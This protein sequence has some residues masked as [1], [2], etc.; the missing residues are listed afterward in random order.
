MFWYDK[1]Q[2]RVMQ[3]K[4]REIIRELEETKNRIL[5]ELSGVDKVTLTRLREVLADYNRID[6]N[7]N[8]KIK[9]FMEN[10]NVIL[11]G[12]EEVASLFREEIRKIS[13]LEAQLNILERNLD[14]VT[15]L[16]FG[17]V[18]D[19]VTD[20]SDAMIEAIEKGVEYG[21][22]VVI[23][24]NVNIGVRK[25]LF[26]PSNLH[27]IINGVLRPI[28]T[29]AMSL[30]TFDRV[31][32]TPAYTS[33][34][35]V[36]IEGN[37]VID[38]RCPEL[39]NYSA[40]IRI[41]HASNVTIKD[42]T[43][44]NNCFFHFIEIGASKNVTID[45]VK[46]IDNYVDI[47][48]YE[49]Y[50]GYHEF[51]QLEYLTESGAN[52]AIPFDTT[53]IKNL[54]IK[55]CLFTKTENGG[56]L[57]CA[58]GSHTGYLGDRENHDNI[59]I[60]NCIFENGDIPEVIDGTESIYEHTFINIK[61]H[62]NN[63][64]IEKCHFKNGHTAIT[65]N[66]SNVGTVKVIGNIF[67]DIKGH[68]VCD[69]GSKQADWYYFIGNN[70]FNCSSHNNTTQNDT[71]ANLLLRDDCM[72]SVVVNNTFICK[73]EYVQR[74]IHFPRTAIEKEKN[75]IVYGNVLSGE[76]IER[77]NFE[78][79]SHREEVLWSG[80][81]YIGEI[82]VPDL[83]K[84]EEVRIF[85]DI[86]NMPECDFVTLSKLQTQ[87]INKIALPDAPTE[88]SSIVIHEVLYTTGED[89]LTVVC[90]N[91]CLIGKDGLSWSSKNGNEAE[92]SH[93]VKITKI[94]GINHNNQFFIET[95]GE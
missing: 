9:T 29:D 63:V 32:E 25:R 61:P 87:R 73:G 34:H 65:F 59:L 80:N 86:D 53:P 39:E 19:G 35:N 5:K 43:L 72:D 4:K 57:K 91:R 33:S 64:V 58:I 69:Y 24:A 75:L 85:A 76:N 62:F 66:G 68:C 3:H 48:N 27:L 71:Y 38:M 21:V 56:N 81:H 15:P 70:F 41:Y 13:S 94:V 22:P 11:D 50:T 2:E 18:G 36:L 31:T 26:T 12:A 55:N 90:N 78:R 23:P 40:P 52:G 92:G 42:I 46:F 45:N 37:G 20:D 16:M 30:E 14:Y 10:G 1:D 54:T 82:T 17:A 60:S 77:V 6:H 8:E 83:A 84:Y 74:P 47:I 79:Y 7:I 67:E 44:K 51:I 88:D 93:F 28:T 95:K 89:K 49:P